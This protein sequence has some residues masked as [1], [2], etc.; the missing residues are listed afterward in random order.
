LDQIGEYEKFAY[1]R[2]R[3][4]SLNLSKDE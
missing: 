4:W 2:K 3:S 1:D